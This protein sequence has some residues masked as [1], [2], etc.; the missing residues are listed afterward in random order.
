MAVAQARAP[1]ADDGGTLK[2]YN[3]ADPP[4]TGAH[5]TVSQNLSVASN[6]RRTSRLT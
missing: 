6:L 1:I 4:L 5:R 3:T 2:G